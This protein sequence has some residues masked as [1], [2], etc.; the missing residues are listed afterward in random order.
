M[1]ANRKAPAPHLVPVD[2]GERWYAEGSEGAEVSQR[3]AAVRPKSFADTRVV[4]EYFRAGIPVFMNLGDLEH[5][6]A[7]R[8]VDFACG[9]VFSLRGGIERFTSRLYLLTPAGF[10]V[11]DGTDSPPP[12]PSF[13]NQA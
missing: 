8:A 4:G 13:F 3:I 9:L 5:P 12:D 1:V 6:E 2:D 10:E 7:K 11:V